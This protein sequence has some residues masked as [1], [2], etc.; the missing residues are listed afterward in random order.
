[1]LS[2]QSVK[3][4]INKLG[5]SYKT[6][7][8]NFIILTPYTSRDQRR[9][10]LVS[11]QGALK[12]SVFVQ[13]KGAG[14]LKLKISNK[15]VK[16]YIKP[17][18]TGSGVLLKPNLFPNMTDVE[19]K[20]SAYGT[21]LIQSIELT[22][23]SQ[24]QKE[25]LK[26]LTRYHLNE[27]G[28]A[29]LK[30]TFSLFKD[31][32]PLNTINNDFSELLGPLAVINMKLL[33][34]PKSNSTVFVPYRGNFPLLDYKITNGK[35]V[36]KISAK[37]GDTTNTLKP[38][39]VVELIEDEASLKSKYSRSTE[40]NVIKI[41]KE[42]TVKQGPIEAI[43]YLKSLGFK[44]ANFL[45]TKVYTEELR[46]QCEDVLV[47]LSKEDIDFTPLFKDATNA[48][49]HYIKFSLSSDGTPTWK[50]LKEDKERP[51]ISSKRIVFRSKNYVGR[52]A[53][54]LGFQPK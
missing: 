2:E 50:Y 3:K 29:A 6:D 32:I 33:K 47:S 46:Q 23:L 12:E 10:V 52:A 13:D 45:T 11:L 40:F 1:M 43:D 48:K 16:I 8:N 41:L 51:D 36:Y 30:K 39:D 7:Q 26:A 42:N 19:I 24:E 27:I 20:F 15:P 49:I 54:K 44:K 18:K 34:I 21:R 31:T 28:L 9:S 38:G 22:E 37:S 17:E 14:F 53:D 5:L 25:L 4:E 35:T